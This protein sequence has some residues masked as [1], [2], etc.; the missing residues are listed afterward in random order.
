MQHTGFKIQSK[1]KYMQIED[2]VENLLSGDL[3]AKY[4]SHNW[5]KRGRNHVMCKR[6]GS[7]FHFYDPHNKKQDITYH[8]RFY[9][10]VGNWRECGFDTILSCV[11]M[12]IKDI[13]E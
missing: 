11:D 12:Q 3:L 10:F 2:F 4:K 1:I 9:T 8:C 7:Y 5:K 13:I 6:C